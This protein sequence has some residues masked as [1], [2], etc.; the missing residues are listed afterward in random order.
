MGHKVQMTQNKHALAEVKMTAARTKQHQK[1]KHIVTTRTE[2]N[3]KKK[4]SKKIVLKASI[5]T[6]L[7]VSATKPSRARC[8]TSCH[9]LPTLV[10]NGVSMSTHCNNRQRYLLWRCSNI[11]RLLKQSSQMMY[12]RDCRGQRP[13]VTYKK[14]GKNKT[15][16]R[17]AVQHPLDL[18]YV[19][20]GTWYTADV[21]G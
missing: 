13:K 7:P 19:I 1:E 10:D 12:F 21:V 17:T 16:T 3:A 8:H 14:R 20:P 5:A 4:K 11:E 9:L 6:K 2:K 18:P 15:I